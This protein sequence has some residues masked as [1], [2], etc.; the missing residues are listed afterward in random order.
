MSISFPQ[1][2]VRLL[3]REHAVTRVFEPDC[4]LPASL[5]GASPRLHGQALPP[6][7]LFNGLSVKQAILC[8]IT[9][10]AA[11]E[12]LTQCKSQETCQGTEGG[13]TFDKAS[14]REA[15]ETGGGTGQKPSAGEGTNFAGSSEFLLFFD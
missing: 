13:H 14:T 5:G 9:M 4:S 6:A 10:L 1:C 12:H 7:W 11:Y 15:S 2:P 3:T 8:N